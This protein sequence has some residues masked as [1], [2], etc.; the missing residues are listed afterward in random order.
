M[1]NNEQDKKILPQ[2]DLEF[3]LMTT[4]PVWGSTDVS[5]ELRERL[6]Q[7]FTHVDDDQG[8]QTGE[9]GATYYSKESMWGLLGSYTRDMRLAN[10]NG[11]EM[12]FCQYYLDLANDLLQAGMVKAFLVSLTRVATRLELSQSRSGFLRKR[13]GTFTTEQKSETIEPRKRPLLGG[14]KNLEVS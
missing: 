9:P 11:R 5:T 2:T 12:E 13:M 8:T 7:Y 4:D 3:Y 10:L 14:K 1:T 6:S